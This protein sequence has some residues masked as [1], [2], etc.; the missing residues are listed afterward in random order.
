MIYIFTYL[1]SGWVGLVYI[2][3]CYWK[4]P[5]PLKPT[6]ITICYLKRPRQ[7]PQTQLQFVT[8]ACGRT[9]HWWNSIFNAPKVFHKILSQFLSEIFVLCKLCWL[10]TIDHQGDGHT[11]YLSYISHMRYVEK[12]L[13]CWEILDLYAWQMWRYLK[14]LHMWSNFK[15]L[16]MTDA[17]KSENFPHVES[18]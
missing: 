12:N 16:H 14:F 3:Q 6:P 13:S 8:K 9:A 18:F 1:R 11:W 2:A 7:G 10:L 15:F 4:P 5:T 17:E